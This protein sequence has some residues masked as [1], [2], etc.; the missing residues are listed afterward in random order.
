MPW[1]VENTVYEE[2]YGLLDARMS[3]GS[4]DGRWEA[5]LYGKNLGDELYRVDVIP[6][7][8]D[9]FARYAPP[10]SYGLQLTTNF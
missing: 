1:G 9:V 6:F 5:A 8:G 4:R 7:L 3:L 10:R 2:S